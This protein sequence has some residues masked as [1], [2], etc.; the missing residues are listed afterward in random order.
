MGIFAHSNGNFPKKGYYMKNCLNELMKKKGITTEGLSLR[1]GVAKNTI[2]KLRND[3]VDCRISTIL[4]L[5]D[6][7]NVSISEFLGISEK[8]NFDFFLSELKRLI[9]RYYNGKY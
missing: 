5:T 2:S 1:C 9:R 4:K 3:D 7:F 8:C 6:F